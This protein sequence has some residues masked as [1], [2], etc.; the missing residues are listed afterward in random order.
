MT[1]DTDSA[2]DGQAE[3]PDPDVVDLLEPA[4]GVPPLVADATAL[5]D[6]AARLASGTGPVAVDAERASGYRYSARA[7]LVQLRREGTGTLLVDPIA[8]GGD[9][10]ALG[11]ALRGVEWVLHAASQDLACLDEV[12]M[13]PDRL[14]DTELAGRLVGYPRVGLGPLTE[15]LLGV[16]LQKGHGAADWSRRPLPDDWLTYAALDVELLVDLRDAVAADLERQGKTAWAEQEFEA[17]R[18]APPPPPRAEPWR[19]TSGLH[20][21]RRPA[22]LAV[23]RSLY[24]SRDELAAARDVAPGRLLPDAAIVDAAVRE[25]AT[26]DDLTGMPVFRGR[27]QRRLAERWWSAIQ[28]ARALPRTELPASAAAPDGPP[29]AHR[30]GDKDPAAAA[31]LAAAR[32]A[33]AGL[34]ER[35]GTPVE[36]LVTPD[37]VRRLCWSPPE[38][39]A[40]AV[41]AALRAL[42]ARPWQAELAA[43]LLAEA[44]RAEPPAAEDSAQESDGA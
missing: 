26:R 18:L 21:V 7:Y 1:T 31:R 14:F 32:A 5:A 44:L 29:P 37:L 11:D 3:A 35:V 19:R 25:P 8:C 2:P 15:H 38:A 17:V 9:L 42:G 43:P 10:T 16:R 13:R 40:D 20:K 28:Q 36:N 39:D 33:L 30:W 24:R 12:G 6:A 22:Q 23:V 27:A 4:D 41:G 34:S